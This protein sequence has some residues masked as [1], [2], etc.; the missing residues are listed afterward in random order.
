[1]ATSAIRTLIRDNKMHQARS[2]MEGARRDG[3]VTMDHALKDLYD[4]GLVSY[5]AAQR[6]LSN[7]R[8]L[9]APSSGQTPPAA[10]SFTSAARQPVGGESGDAK[11]RFPWSK[12]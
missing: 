9:Q 4:E 8:G 2:I 12:V 5:E 10:S 7:P 6:F 11:G 1:M 3:M